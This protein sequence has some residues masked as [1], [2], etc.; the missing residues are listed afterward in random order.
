M[1]ALGKAFED[2]WACIAP[3]VSTRAKADGAARLTLADI[4]LGLAKAG[5]FDP[6]KLADAAVQRCSLA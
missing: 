4:I 5:N 1:K 6:Q 2:P 3:S